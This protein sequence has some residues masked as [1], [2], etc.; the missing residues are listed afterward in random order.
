MIFQEE[1]K[2]AANNTIFDKVTN[3]NYPPRINT[4]NKSLFLNPLLLNL[5]CTGMVFFIPA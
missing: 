3:Y 4:P 5:L 2:V 1:N